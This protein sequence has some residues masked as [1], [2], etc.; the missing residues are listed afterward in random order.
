MRPLTFFVTGG[1][2]GIG[3][4]IVLEAARSGHD[5]A[6]TYATNESAAAEVARR[7]REIRPEGRYRAYKLDVRSSAEVEAI[8]SGS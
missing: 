7:A 4:G 8:G 5:V 2:R 1:S 3:S 6:F